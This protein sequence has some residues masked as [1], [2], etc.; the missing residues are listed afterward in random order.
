MLGFWAKYKRRENESEKGEPEG[1]S[2]RQESRGKWHWMYTYYFVIV[3]HLIPKKLAVFVLKRFIKIYNTEPTKF[4]D[5]RARRALTLRALMRKTSHKCQ[6]WV[7]LFRATILFDSSWR[8]GQ[9]LV[10]M[11]FFFTKRLID[12]NIQLLLLYGKMSLLVLQYLWTPSTLI[13]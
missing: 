5:A 1:E 9:A 3:I 12:D 2:Q 6:I 7:N 4:C 11:P 8:N 10:F 13:N